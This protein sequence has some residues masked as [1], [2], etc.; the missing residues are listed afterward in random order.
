MHSYL[1]WIEPGEYSGGGT[2]SHQLDGIRLAQFARHPNQSFDKL[3]T[4]GKFSNP[5]RVSV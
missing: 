4:N 1:N 2:R 3:R 5:F